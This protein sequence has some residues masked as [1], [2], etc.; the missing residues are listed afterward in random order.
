M[1]SIGLLGLGLLGSA[2]AERLLSR[3][4]SVSGFD[5]DPERNVALS[6]SGGVALAGLSDVAAFDVIV[7]S[8]PTSSVVAEVVSSIKGEL[9]AGQTIVDTTTG[10]PADVESVAE[11]L[12]EIDVDYLDATIGGSSQQ[13]REGDAII[14]CGGPIDAFERCCGL[15]D[16]IGKRTFHLGRAG[17]GS[18]M[19][20]AVNLV[21]GLN[22]V[23]LAE[24][25]S[26]AGSIG[27]DPAITLEV[28]KASPAASAVMATKGQ[29]MLDSD[30]APQARLAQHL[31]D[32]RVILETGSATGARLPMSSAHRT[33]LEELD[34]AG[35]GDLDNSAII[36]AFRA[37]E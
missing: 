14:M 35:K 4:W 16:D 28:L 34:G 8:L 19:K 18:R 22:R 32:V 15:F 25:L 36:E 27:L 7:L 5:V 26:Y 37:A 24:G 23:V 17:S 30:F 12:A 11:V 9:R 2:L 3:G 13:T 20:L 31:K 21:L 10:N 6:N 1:K 33:L 29:K